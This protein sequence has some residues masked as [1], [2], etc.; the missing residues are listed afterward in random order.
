MID[1]RLILACARLSSAAYDVFLDGMK[2]PGNAVAFD[3]GGSHALGQTLP[4]AILVAYQGT[5]SVDVADIMSNLRI[6]PRPGPN[7]GWCHAGYKSYALAP[8]GAAR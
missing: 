2:W 1:P 6:D 5:D 3:E 8:W 7:G 4:D